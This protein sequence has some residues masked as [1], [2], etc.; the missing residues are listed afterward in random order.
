MMYL[1]GD[2]WVRKDKMAAG[3]PV[4][5]PGTP[6]NPNT[7]RVNN[8]ILGDPRPS[9]PEIGETLLRPQDEECGGADPGTD[10]GRL[11]IVISENRRTALSDARQ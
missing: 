2:A 11:E 1:G 7:P 8:G 10:R 9:T 4:L 5:P 3:D 6:Q